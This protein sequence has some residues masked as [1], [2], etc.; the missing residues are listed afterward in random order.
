MNEQYM[1]HGSQRV[2]VLQTNT[3]TAVVQVG[4]MPPY[5]VNRKE[6]MPDIPVIAELRATAPQRLRVETVITN[7]V[8]GRAITSYATE[9]LYELIRDEECALDLLST[10][11]TKPLSLTRELDTRAAQLDRLVQLMNEVAK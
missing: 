8:N 7:L 10:I 2:K 5:N 1:Y 4:G 9:E 3:V 11:K 6:L